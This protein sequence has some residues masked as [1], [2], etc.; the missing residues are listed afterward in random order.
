MPT[1]IHSKLM[2]PGLE[3]AVTLTSECPNS[4]ASEQSYAHSA[5]EKEVPYSPET[6]NILRYKIWHG[7]G[8]V[9]KTISTFIPV[10]I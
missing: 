8:R 1:S 3:R 6:T 9:R 5:V 7:E 2:Y 4:A 10:N